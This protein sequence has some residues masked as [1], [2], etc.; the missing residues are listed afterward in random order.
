MKIHIEKYHQVVIILTCDNCEF[1]SNNDS[2]L[3]KHEEKYHQVVINLTCDNCDFTSKNESD[4]K[5]HEEAK[6]KRTT[7]SHEEIT[8]ETDDPIEENNDNNK[9]ER[10]NSV[11]NSPLSSPPNKKSTVDVSVLQ[12][13]VAALN[14]SDESVTSLKAK[15]SQLE[16]SLEKIENDYAKMINENS[17]MKVAY[18]K[19]KKDISAERKEFKKVKEENGK[20]NLE[21]GTMQFEK[22]KMEAKSKSDLKI[23][24]MK[25]NTKLFNKIIEN[26]V[27][28]GKLKDIDISKYMVNEMEECDGG[29]ASMESTGYGSLKNLVLNK[30]LGGRRTNPQEKSEVGKQK[31]TKQTQI[32]KCPQCDFLSQNEIYFNEHIS[33]V[34]SNQQTCPFCFM[35]FDSYADVRKHCESN[36]SER[37]S[38]VKSKQKEGI[39]KP[40]RFFRN[41]TG[42]CSPPSGVCNYDHTITPDSERELCYHKTACW[43]KPRCIFF[44]PEGQGTDEWKQLK[45]PS[46]VCHFSL[47]GG[48]CMRSVCNF[49][50]PSNMN[51]PIEHPARRNCSVFH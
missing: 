10:N 38:E 40:C 44:H 18:D 36:H 26:K 20:L 22:D 6:H 11:S 27:A 31:N 51:N 47:N 35:A 17:S 37:K 33:K 45:N 5:R 16:K 49:F 34:H 32:F 15:V 41:G 3:K 50:H 30:Q 25:E 8:M 4:L 13:E 39:K 14:L 2:N 43:Y 9:R 24:K 29:E 23:K 19:L 28:T 12:D 46:Q 1:T 7:D 42:R 48:T 21:I